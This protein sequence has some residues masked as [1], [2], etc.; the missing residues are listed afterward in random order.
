M[1][2]A[3]YALIVAA[4]K[5]RDTRLPPLGAPGQDAKKLLYRGPNQGQEPVLH[6]N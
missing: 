3:R 2:E 5:Y 4:S 1:G 6:R